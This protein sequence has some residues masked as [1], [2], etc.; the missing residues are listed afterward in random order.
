MYKDRLDWVDLAKGFGIILVVYGHVARGLSSAGQSFVFFRQ[1]DNAIYAFHMP[2]FFLLSGY[3]FT[4]SAQKGVALYIKSKLGTILYPYLIWSLLQIGVQFLASNYINGSVSFFD[5]LT[6][7]VPRSQFWFLLALLL[8]S[9]VNILLYRKLG[10]KGIL[11]SSVVSLVYIL[12]EKTKI[13]VASDTLKNILFF[14]IGI[15][16]YEYSS[17]MKFVII[18]KISV[19][20]NGVL[21]AVLQSLLWVRDIDSNLFS[22][23]IAISGSVFVIQLCN[24]KFLHCSHLKEIGQQSM[25]IYILH[26]L[27]ASGTRIILMKIF[28]VEYVLL[29]IVIG[30]IFGIYIPFLLYK[31]GIINKV[32][33]LFN[34]SMSKR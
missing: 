3:F 10:M 2:L 6:F 9:I 26:I 21:F 18:S 32:S 30:T 11:I 15:F 23:L 25:V 14:N 17:L 22:L 13:E 28:H 29:H 24:F 1:I 19:V 7:F 27:V 8:I 31:S 16:L 5:V 20:V 12:F 4:K 34:Y 33:I